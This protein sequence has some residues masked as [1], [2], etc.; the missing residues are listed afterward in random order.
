MTTVRKLMTWLIWIPIFSMI[1]LAL[2]AP[3]GLVLYALVGIISTAY[4][5]VLLYTIGLAVV[6]YYIQL[7]RQAQEK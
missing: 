2:Y 1:I 4:T 7:Q 5:A 6:D 3:L